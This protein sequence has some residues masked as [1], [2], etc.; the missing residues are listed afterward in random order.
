M[1]IVRGV[2][3]LAVALIVGSGCGHGAASKPPAAKADGPHVM[4]D[5]AAL[6]TGPGGLAAWLTYGLERA[7]LVEKR[8]GHFHNQS[9]DDFDVELGAREAMLQMWTDKRGES[10]PGNPYLDQLLDVRKAGFLDEYVVM[11]H[12]RPGWTLPGATVAAL[13]LPAFSRWAGEHLRDH[14]P[15]TLVAVAPAA[16]AA[17]LAIPGGDLPDPEELSPQRQ[18]CASSS[19]RLSQLLARWERDAA[20]L[21]G[22]PVGATNRGEL[23]RRL[24]RLR[25]SAEHT[26]RGVTWI[27]PAV[28]RLY[29][30]AGFCA[31]EANNATLARSSLT[32]S[33]ALDPLSAAPRLELVHLLTTSHELDAADLQLDEVL[34]FSRDKCDLGH[35]WRKRGFVLVERS[36]LEQAYAAYQ[37]S[38]EYDP[39]SKIAIREMAFILE[40]SRRLG[41]P[42]ARAFKDARPPAA[43]ETTVTSCTE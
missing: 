27:S 33:A 16:G 28:P 36:K 12:A 38:L 7:A 30:F 11:Y 39:A 24:A 41:G 2:R 32:R 5:R 10:G 17:P 23:A 9:A 43:T 31:V 13:D 3:V 21:D 26:T 29:F 35:A 18:G 22:L 6:A 4:V 20:N 34:A 15:Q 14:K 19:P 8:V 1:G 40:E 25:T 37:K 42:A